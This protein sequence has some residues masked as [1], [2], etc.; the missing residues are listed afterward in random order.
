VARWLVSGSS[1]LIGGAL[2]RAL[3]AGGHSVFRLARPGEGAAGPDRISF[4]DAVSGAAGPFDVVVHLAGAP[5]GEGR[6]TPERRREIRDSR[7][8]STAR[9]ARGVVNWPQPPSLL[10][11]ASAIG[12]YGDRADELLDED[13]DAGSG[14]LAEVCQAW[15]AASQPAES[16]GI[17]VVKIRTSQV[18][19]GRGGAL[20]RLLPLYKAGL[21]GPLGT[22]RQWMST[23]SLADQVAGIIFVAG[24]ESLSGPINLCCPNPCRQG[25]FARS[26]GRALRRPAILPTPASALRLALGTDLANELVLA[27]QRV[28]PTRLLEAGF[29]FQHPSIDEINE[30]ALQD[31][32]SKIDSRD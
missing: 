14:F 21:G 32:P 9:L 12:Y 30:A 27:S 26:L 16:A 31:R 5:I 3:R 29:E 17:R 28:R 2:G 18:I 24:S 7:V 10:M 6:W 13:S 8:E 15:E 25:E 19:S 20:V 11:V 1:G 4:G 22:G 23:I